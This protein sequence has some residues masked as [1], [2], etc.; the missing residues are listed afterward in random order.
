M[1]QRK[2]KYYFNAAVNFTKFI[3]LLIS[4][5]TAFL[6]LLLRVK[7]VHQYVLISVNIMLNIKYINIIFTN[8]YLSEIKVQSG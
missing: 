1:E 7:S 6:L 2:K 4:T 5:C 3:I 8:L